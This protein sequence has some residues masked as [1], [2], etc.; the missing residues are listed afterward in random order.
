MEDNSIARLSK[1]ENIYHVIEEVMEPLSQTE[2]IVIRGKTNENKTL[3][4]HLVIVSYSDDI[5]EQKSVM[6][7]VFEQHKIPVSKMSGATTGNET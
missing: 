4:L 6:C 7:Q 1:L 2:D 3:R 5:A